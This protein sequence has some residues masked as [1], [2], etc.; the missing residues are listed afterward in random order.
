MMPDAVSGRRDWIL[1]SQ[2]NDIDAQAA[3]FKGYGQQ[4]QQLG[5]G[6]FEGRF[7]TFNFGDDLSIHLE[8]ANRAL[9]QSASTPAGR[10]G[11]CLLAETS[12]PFTLNG[13]TSDQNQVGMCPERKSLYGTTS[14]G[15]NIFCLDVSR[16]LLPDDGCQMRWVGA[17]HDSAR[18]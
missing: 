12:P 11:A 2:F 17:Q 6:P 3:Q 15:M 5:R 13:V 8:A 16:D 1:R 14:E 18:P 4:Y 9:A 10:Y 7:C